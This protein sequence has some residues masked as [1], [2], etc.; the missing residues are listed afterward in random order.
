MTER[1]TQRVLTSTC[2]SPSASASA[3]DNSNSEARKRSLL[4]RAAGLQSVYLTVGPC[5]DS[6]QMRMATGGASTQWCI[7]SQRLSE[8]R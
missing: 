4:S 5:R 1:I 7:P 2:A 3:T 6:I 8:L